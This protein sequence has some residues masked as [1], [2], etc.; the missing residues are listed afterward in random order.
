[1]RCVS[2]AHNINCSK[3]LKYLYLHKTWIKRFIVQ[4]L[5]LIS[6]SL[7]YDYHFIGKR[8]NSS[9]IS[10]LSSSL[11]IYS[12]CSKSTQRIAFEAGFEDCLQTEKNYGIAEGEELRFLD[13]ND[14][15]NDFMP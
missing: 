15:R 14:T 4:C 1:M 13:R 11:K 2:V 8:S 9:G 10:M 12:Y 3:D 6:T 5:E 7:I